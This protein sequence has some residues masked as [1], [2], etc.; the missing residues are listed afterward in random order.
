MDVEKPPKFKIKPD[1]EGHIRLF[2]YAGNGAELFRTPAVRKR[3]NAE[4]TLDRI[5]V[6]IPEAEL[7]PGP[8]RG[9]RGP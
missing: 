8:G 2:L 1:E 9:R 3:G 7:E 6:A 5:K 4:R